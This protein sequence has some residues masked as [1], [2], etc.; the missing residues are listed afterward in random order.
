MGKTS[1]IRSAKVDRDWHWKPDIHSHEPVIEVSN[2]LYLYDDKKLKRKVHEINPET[3]QSYCKVE[4]GTSRKLSTV[5]YVPEGRRKCSVCQR[6][7]D[8][9]QAVKITSRKGA[10]RFYSSHE[11][12]ELRY[13][14][15]LEY[16]RECVVC[17]TTK[18][19]T[20]DH[21]KPLRKYPDLARDITNLQVLCR[22][23]NRGKG[24]W[25]ETNWRERE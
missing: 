25:D 12:S 14:A 10:G 22:L 24:D 5:S 23:C 6:L 21:I 19:L 18:N 2:S 7:K 8:E 9:G 16:G 20:V 17:G 1:N 4:N 13:R 15:F 3:G 11:W